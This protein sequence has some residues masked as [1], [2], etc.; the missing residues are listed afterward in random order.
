[1]TGIVRRVGSRPE[2]WLAFVT[3]RGD[4]GQPVRVRFSESPKGVRWRC[5]TCGNSR[6][7][8]CIHTR[9]AALSILGAIPKPTTAK[10]KK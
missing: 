1:M 3:L 6:D 5:D 2:S 9:T 4:I 10:E 8:L 7:A